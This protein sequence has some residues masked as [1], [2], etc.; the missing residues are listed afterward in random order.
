M[1]GLFYALFQGRPQAQDEVLAGGVIAASS[2][3]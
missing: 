2:E 1:T 3:V